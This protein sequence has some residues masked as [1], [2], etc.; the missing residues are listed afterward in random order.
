M[1][2]WCD[3]C[4]KDTHDTKDCWGLGTVVAGPASSPDPMAGKSLADFMPP[5]EAA[6]AA[7]RPNYTKGGKPATFSLFIKLAG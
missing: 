2:P 7:D 3:G 1:K 4:K 5:E 6:L